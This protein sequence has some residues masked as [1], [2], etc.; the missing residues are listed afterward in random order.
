MTMVP[1]IRDVFPDEVEAVESAWPGTEFVGFKS[2][3]GQDLFDIAAR[4]GRTTVFRAVPGRVVRRAMHFGEVEQ[5]FTAIRRELVVLAE[6][7]AEC[8]H[9]QAMAALDPDSRRFTHEDQ[10]CDAERPDY[11]GK[12]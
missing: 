10:G 9:L 5:F 4:V 2:R 12:R 11:R 1:D 8:G 7:V 3:E 6:R